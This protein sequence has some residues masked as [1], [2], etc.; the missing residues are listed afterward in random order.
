MFEGVKECA[1]DEVVCRVWTVK[2]ERGVEGN[3]ST[4]ACDARKRYV[5][6][7]VFFLKKGIATEDGDAEELEE[8]RDPFAD[9]ATAHDA[10]RA[11]GDHKVG[12]LIDLCQ[13]RDNPLHDTPCIR[14]WRIGDCDVVRL[15]VREVDVI[16]ADGRGGDEAH[17]RA[18]EEVCVTLGASAD[19][20][21]GGVMTTFSGNV[22]GGEI[23]HFA[24]WF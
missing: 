15:A 14:A 3:D 10:H 21:D 9:R 17:G 6:E 13:H 22:G 8:L 4:F 2:G 20:E 18:L 1:V 19:K 16:G 24:V 23:E 11:F 7:R 12:T 5:T